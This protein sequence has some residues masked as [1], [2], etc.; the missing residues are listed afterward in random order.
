MQ[1]NN[2]IVG[3]GVIVVR[4]GKVLV[5]KR[6]GSHGAGTWAFPGGHLEFGETIEDCARREVREETGLELGDIVSGP[7]TNNVFPE[8][9]RHYVTLFVVSTSSGDPKV[10]EPTKCSEWQ[11]VAWDD[12]PAPLFPPLQTLRQTSFK[13]DQVT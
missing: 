12:F 3:V 8:I 2:P 10:L 4:A 6:L 7:Y 13:P 11:W 1:S 9:E 5:G